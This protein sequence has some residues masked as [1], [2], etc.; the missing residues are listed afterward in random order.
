MVGT[1]ATGGTQTVKQLYMHTD[2]YYPIEKRTAGR[3]FALTDDSGP[4]RISKT[5]K[6][7]MKKKGMKKVVKIAKHKLK[8]IGK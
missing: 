3:D 1:F 5:P 7:A 8:Q 2:E 4:L 6:K